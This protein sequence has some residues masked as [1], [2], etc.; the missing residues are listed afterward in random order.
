M[1]GGTPKHGGNPKGV[2]YLKEIWID[3]CRTERQKWSKGVEARIEEMMADHS[4]E[5]MKGIN[6]QIQEAP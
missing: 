1:S 2:S 4:P 3:L 5:L 6:P